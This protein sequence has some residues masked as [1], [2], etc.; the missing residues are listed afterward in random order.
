ME[1][2]KQRFDIDPSQRFEEQD[3]SYGEDGMERQTLGIR[4][5]GKK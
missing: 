5:E 2:K 4:I 1:E 3:A